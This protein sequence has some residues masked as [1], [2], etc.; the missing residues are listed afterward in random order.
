MEI[1]TSPIPQSELVGSSRERENN[2]LYYWEEV[3]NEAT[4][5]DSNGGGDPDDGGDDKVTIPVVTMTPSANIHLL[6]GMSPCH[7][8]S[9]RVCRRVLSSHGSNEAGD[10]GLGVCSRR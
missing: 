9:F 5:E 4:P 6:C 1:A 2:D 7:L 3:P 10:G 8:G